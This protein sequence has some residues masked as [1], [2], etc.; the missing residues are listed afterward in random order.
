[1]VCLAGALATA[2]ADTGEQQRTAAVAPTWTSLTTGSGALVSC[3]G[4]HSGG[5]PAGGLS[6][7]EADFT[8]VTTMTP[9]NCGLTSMV[10]PGT[11]E[12]SILYV[13]LTNPGACTLRTTMPNAAAAA[14]DVGAWI[15][16]GALQ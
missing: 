7:T 2:C 13:V 12:T 16:G 11:K 5:A 9:S 15:D 4:C 1:M 14:P 3:Q 8:A 6:L 10:T